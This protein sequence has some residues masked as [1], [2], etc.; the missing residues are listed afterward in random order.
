[1]LDRNLP[2]F[3]IDWIQIKLL[4]EKCLTQ[5]GY[6]CMKFMPFVDEDDV[7]Q[8]G[9]GECLLLPDEFVASDAFKAFIR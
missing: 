9:S 5:E 4:E 1:M 6:L 7:N 2:R 3:G 8:V